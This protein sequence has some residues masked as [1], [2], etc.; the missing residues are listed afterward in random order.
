MSKFEQ[1]ITKRCADRDLLLRQYIIY[2]FMLH[3]KMLLMIDV[4]GVELSV[5]FDQILSTLGNT[6]DGITCGDAAPLVGGEEQ[7]L[8]LQYPTPLSL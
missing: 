2:S 8:L 3:P 5:Q 7:L 1:K 6:T 4:D